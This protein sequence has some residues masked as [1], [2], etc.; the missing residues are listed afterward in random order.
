[1]NAQGIVSIAH[2]VIAGHLLQQR[3]TNSSKD[4]QSQ[5]DLCNF[6]MPAAQPVMRAQAALMTGLQGDTLPHSCEHTCSLACPL[7]TQYM[8]R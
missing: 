8:A 4:H 6:T 7:Q 5:N 3:H 2:C 1:M